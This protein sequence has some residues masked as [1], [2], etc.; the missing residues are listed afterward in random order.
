MTNEPRASENPA[1]SPDDDEVLDVGQEEVFSRTEVELGVIE[2]SIGAG[3]ADA[4]VTV[5]HGRGRGGP[6]AG[7]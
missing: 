6:M 1:P 7:L 2:H 3:S 4:P 5:D